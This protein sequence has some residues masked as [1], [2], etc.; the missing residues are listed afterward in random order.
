MVC[1]VGG[2]GRIASPTSTGSIFTF[3][4]FAVSFVAGLADAFV[5]LDGVLADGVDAAVVEALCTLVHIYTQKTH[6]Q[7]I[8]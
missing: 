5:G 4:M 3:T 2:G 6:T 7:G 8:R 1:T